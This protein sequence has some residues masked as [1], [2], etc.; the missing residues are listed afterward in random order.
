MKRRPTMKLAQV[1]PV[2]LGAFVE[3]ELRRR[4][5]WAWNA[6]RTPGV[7][8]GDPPQ[9]DYGQLTEA[10]KAARGLAVYAKTGAGLSVDEAELYFRFLWRWVY[11]P[12]F[13]TT[14]QAD[15]LDLRDGVP[16]IG[17]GEEDEA[18][19]LVLWATRGRILLARR[20]GVVSSELEALTGY[21]RDYLRKL[22]RSNVLTRKSANVEGGVLYSAES[23]LALCRSL[24]VAGSSKR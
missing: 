20:K 16:T 11:A 19:K 7:A 3:R 23:A 22:A 12:P 5:S 13:M 17:G 10:A 18:L 1:D 8:M 2:S 21:T 14:A 4:L 9:P 15:A 24:G 6:L